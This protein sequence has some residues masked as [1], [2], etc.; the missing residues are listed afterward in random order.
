MAADR[1]S[2]PDQVLGKSMHPEVGELEALV[3][4]A[5]WVSVKFESLS[6][7]QQSIERAR[8]G[9]RTLSDGPPFLKSFPLVIG[10]TTPGFFFG[11]GAETLVGGSPDPTET[12]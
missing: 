1:E 7:M 5:A 8:V 4:L 10:R 6:D 12:V 9:L 3:L 11:T 2:H